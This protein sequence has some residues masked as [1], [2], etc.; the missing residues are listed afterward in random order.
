MAWVRC[1]YR[2]IPSEYVLVKSTGL[3]VLLAEPQVQ[4]TGENFPPLQCSIPKLGG[5]G[6]WW[7]HLSS[8][9]K[10]HRPTLCCHLFGAQG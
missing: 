1:P 9:K 10:L 2:E 4:R 6:R 8:L 7:C 3:K 5:E